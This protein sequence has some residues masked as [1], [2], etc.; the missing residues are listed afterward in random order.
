MSETPALATDP[1]IIVFTDFDGTV[2]L[3]DSNDYLTEHL[4]FGEKRRKEIND[5]ILV[6]SKSFRQGFQEMLES[7]HTPFPECIE[8]L[9]KHIDLDPGFKDF[10]HWA[11]E[12]NVPI[13]VVSSG[14]EP[15]IRALLAKLVG[16]EAAEDIQI[17]SNHVKINEDGS[18][19]IVYRDESSFGHDKSRAI[20]PYKTKIER[21]TLLYCGDGVSDL[22]AARET[23][24]LFAKK[25]KDLIKYCV[26]E[27]IPYTVFDSFKDI[28]STVEKLYKG[29]V[30]IEVL[31]EVP[32]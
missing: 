31:N 21:P 32:N 12:N 16:Q 19:H 2:T 1:K 4:G 28:H 6:E 24:L 3:Q 5:E 20:R 11:K 7:I 15:I 13:V 29:D 14:M 23:D 9:K 25:G 26:R 17:V 27:R 8:F 18:W 10:Y 30:E 22:S